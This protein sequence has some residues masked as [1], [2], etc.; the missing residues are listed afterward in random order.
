MGIEVPLAT[1]FKASTIRELAHHLLN[2]AQFGIKEADEAMVLLSGKTAGSNIFALPPGTGDAIGYFQLAD[3]LK[4][5]TFYGFNF[6]VAETR[7]KDYADL[8]M[9]IDADG[10]YV[11]FGYSSGGNL[12]YHVT[13]VL[14]ER[15]KSVSDI[16]MVDSSRTI[17]KIQFPEGEAQRV[18]EQFLNH[19]SIAPYL[20]SPVLKDKVIR[21]IECYY[22]YASK[23]VDNDIVNANIHVLI[24]EESQEFE[25]DESGRVVVSLPGWADV[26]RGTFK[27]Y[28]AA[29]DHNHM[30]YP[31]HLDT[32]IGI[33]RQI[34]TQSI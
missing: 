32:N 21:Q 22:A 16:I 30:L 33:L 4:P 24:S 23:T 13:K 10:P 14:E 5:Y 3:L 9:S 28:Q 19:E 34:L 27:T 1:V 15:G 7:L 31:P 18:A 20:T 2:L 12:A 6:I 17:E 26:T 8:I 25:K 11:L 29:G